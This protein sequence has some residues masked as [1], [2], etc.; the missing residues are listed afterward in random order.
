ML[1]NSLINLSLFARPLACSTRPDWHAY[2][3]LPDCLKL[4]R[5]HKGLI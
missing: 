5:A 1:N 3:S 2:Q 4:R